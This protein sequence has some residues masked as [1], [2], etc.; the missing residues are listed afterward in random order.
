MKVDYAKRRRIMQ[1]SMKLGHC[2]CDPKRPCPCDVFNQQGIC[3]C[4]GERPEPIDPASIKL[5][6][7]V[8]N[9]GCASKIAPADLEGVLDR[10]PP[11]EDPRV[12]CGLGAGDD[13]GIY[14]LDDETFLV[15]TVDVMTPVVDDPELFGRICAANCLSDIY[16]MGGEPRTALSV[17]AFPAETMDG[18]IMYLMMRGAMETLAEA[19]VALIGGHSIKDEQIKLGFAV[20]GLLC[21]DKA[22]SHEAAAV[23]DRLVLTKPLGC[24]TLGFARQI[25]REVDMQPVEA[26]MAALNRSACQAAGEV[27]VSAG[28]DVTGFG[29]FG[30]LVR[31]VRHSQ[32]TAEVWADQLPALPGALEALA[33]EIIPGAI[34]RNREFVADDIEIAPGLDPARMHLGFD[35]QTSGGLLLAVAE[36]KHPALLEALA[37]RGATGWTIGRIAEDSPG[38][39][40]LLARADQPLTDLSGPEDPGGQTERHEPSASTAKAPASGCCGSSDPAEAPEAEEHGPGCCAEVFDPAR[41]PAAGDP[42]GSSSQA[43]G[44]AF[45]QFMAASSA[46]GAVDAVS[47]ELVNFALVV[48]AR[49]EPCVQAHLNKASKMG[50]TRTQLDEVAWQAAAMGGAPVRMFYLEM[51]EKYAG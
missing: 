26:S 47:K 16:A 6:E 31:M 4:A 27:G 24:G 22:L 32:V 43:A 23:G 20:T 40:R 29:L 14:R 15:Q 34:E 46:D 8:H 3:P 49:C 18:Q 41:K 1:R 13:A 25:G 37:R 5:T 7:L 28:T 21:G 44:K 48:M 2:I 36:D 30:H 38:R 35:A 11:V 9:A 17:V 45:G 51:M 19:G 10:L 39:I 12:L 50:I 42:E 33:E